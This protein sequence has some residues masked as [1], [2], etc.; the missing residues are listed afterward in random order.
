MAKGRKA[1]QN[2]KKK[3]LSINRKARIEKNLSEA[4]NEFYH[5]KER[6]AYLKYVK[7]QDSEVTK[8]ED[9]VPLLKEKMLRW[10]SKL[11]A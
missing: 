4:R 6:L 7:S 9:L 1:L 11:N 5:S 10:E 2:R 3:K 8:L